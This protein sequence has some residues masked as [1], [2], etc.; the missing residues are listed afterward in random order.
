MVDESVELGKTG[1]RISPIGIGIMQWRDIDLGDSMS[2]VNKDVLDIYRTALDGGITF[3]DTAEAYGSGKSEI[4]L[5]KCLKASPPNNIVIATKFMP[6]PWR[7]TKSELR[8]ALRR[9]LARLG[10]SRVDLYQMHWPFPP[11][12]IPVWMEVM[13]DAVADGLIG[14]VGVSNYSPAQTKQAYEVLAGRKIPLAS[15]QVK[16]NLLDRRPERSGLVE[17]CKNLGISIIAYSPLE[18]GILSGKYTPENIPNGYRAWRYNKNYLLKIKPLFETLRQIGEAH[19]GKSTGQVALSWLTAKG[20]VPIPGARNMGQAKE[21]CG[22]LGWKLT[23][24]EVTRLDQVSEE[25]TR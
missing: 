7:L 25:V 22:G 21:N 13:A 23:G 17:L 20:A 14:A 1:I 15:N 12:P 24:E 8:A 19:E 9:S 3:F 16:F 11:V 6:Y 4:H 5:G 18:K 2:S 10:L